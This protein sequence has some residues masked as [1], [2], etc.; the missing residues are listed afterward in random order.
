MSGRNLRQLCV[1]MSAEL[2]KVSEWMKANMLSLNV[3]KTP[4]MLFMHKVLNREVVEIDIGG[5]VVQQARSAKFLGI[6]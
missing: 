4:F 6:L 1:D 2:L 5:K 3:N